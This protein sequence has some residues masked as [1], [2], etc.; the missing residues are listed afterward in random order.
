MYQRLDVNQLKLVFALFHCSVCIHSHNI[1]LYSLQCYNYTEDL[2]TVLSIKLINH[3]LT[4]P[5][6]R[7]RVSPINGERQ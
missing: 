2:Y 5:N 4:S 1:L 7:N 3:S 6:R